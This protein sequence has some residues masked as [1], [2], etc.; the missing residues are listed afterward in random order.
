M[1]FPYLYLLEERQRLVVFVV[2]FRG[3]HLSVLSLQDDE[4]A[5]HQEDLE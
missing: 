4:G 5:F 2:H 3:Q 1:L